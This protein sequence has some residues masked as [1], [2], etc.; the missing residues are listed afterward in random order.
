MREL[1]AEIHYDTWILPVL[2]IIPLIGTALIFLLCPAAPSSGDV[3]YRGGSRARWITLVTLMVEFVVSIGMWWAFDPNV[4]GWQFYID[5]PWLPDLHSRFTIGV[6]GISLFMVL[7]TTFLMPLAALGDWTSVRTKLRTHYALLLILTTGMIGV[8]VALDFLLF[9]VFWEIMLVPMYFVIGIW[10]GSR[11]IYASEK[12]FIYTMGGSLLML[13]A[14]LVV[15]QSI[16]ADTFSYDQTVARL[17]L[18]PVQSLWLFGAFF[19]AF[20]IKVPLFPFHTWLPDAHVE[21]PTGGSVILAG[22]MLKMGAYGFL[23]FALPLFPS[24]AMHPAVRGIIIGLAVV[25]IVYGDMVDMV[26][27]DL[28]NLV[29]Y[30]SIRQL[31]FVMLGIFALT[32]QSVQG[33]LVIMI[34][35]GVSTAGLFLLVGMLYERTHT[36]EISSYGGIAK[37]VPMFAAFLMLVS[38]ASIGLPGTSGFVGEFLVLVGSYKTYPFAAIIAASGVIFAAVYLLWALQRVVFNPLSN[39][40]NRHLSDLNRR[41]LGMMGVI[42]LVIIGLGVAP[43]PMLR[44]MEAA[45]S[46]LIEHV[47][48]GHAF[49]EVQRAREQTEQP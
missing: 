47:E 3:E 45:T 36:R 34:S 28:K 31:V 46:Q 20:A 16:G 15:W 39:E 40:E 14:I 12:F 17:A 43:G 5:A 10:G 41:E 22:V 6:D 11:R 2:L 25:S 42:A 1:L 24:V 4:S 38:L 23:R 49:A 37:V 44:R 30:S 35:H 9:Y 33:A 29:A 19:L 8:F 32:M 48:R 21:A 7:L 13:V 26:Q 18:T 27:P